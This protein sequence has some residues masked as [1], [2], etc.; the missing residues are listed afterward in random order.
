MAHARKNSQSK[1]EG[2]RVWIVPDAYLPP[3]TAEDEAKHASGQGYWSHE[4]LCI[5]NTGPKPAHLSLNFYFEDRPPVKN[6][7]VTVGAER[8]WHIRFDKPELLGGFRVPAGVPYALRVESNVPVV[9]QHSRLDTTQSNCAFLSVVAH[10][11][12]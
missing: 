8:T 9:V 6:I 3:L 2:R 5:V 12:R 11:V 7:R 1:P 10:P 4:S